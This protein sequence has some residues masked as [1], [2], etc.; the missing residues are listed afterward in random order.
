MNNNGGL[1][2]I[3]NLFTASSELYHF[4]PLSPGN[5]L[6]NFL[7]RKTVEKS[8]MTDVFSL[9]IFFFQVP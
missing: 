7:S 5:E 6:P 4:I 2:K 9:F 8:R 3:D 1:K